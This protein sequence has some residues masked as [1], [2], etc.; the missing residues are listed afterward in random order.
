MAHYP[1][2]ESIHGQ[3][4][5]E[6]FGRYPWSFLLQNDG[7]RAWHTE[8]RYPLKPRVL[9][10]KWQDAATQ[11]GVRFGHKT[12]YAM[13]DIDT[14][15]E[16]LNSAKIADLTA[17]LETMGIVRVVR[18]RS[19]FSGGLHLFLPLPELVNTFN[20]AVAL[21]GTLQA[22]GFTVA[23]GQLEIF[24]NVKAFGKFWK[25]EFTE[26]QG[27]RL[28][29]QPGSGSALL[30]ESFQ[31]VGATLERFWWTWDFAAQA[32]DLDLLLQ[33][34]S[35]GKKNRRRHKRISTP[36]EQ[37]RSDLETQIKDGWTDFGQTNHML[38][39]LGT[40][41]RVFLGL[42]GSEL[43]DFI[44]ERAI[45][46]P[47]FDR[48]C[49][50]QHEIHRKALCWAR[51]LENYYFPA[52]Q[53]GTKGSPYPSE[54]VSTNGNQERSY[55]AQK[56][57]WRAIE[58]I[59]SGIEAIPDTIGGWV[60]R[61]V[62]LAKV[63]SRTLYKHPEW[64]HPRCKKP[65]DTSYLSLLEGENPTSDDQTQQTPQCPLLK[66]FLHLPPGMKSSPTEN[67]H[68]KNLPQGERGGAG[69]EGGLS[70]GFEGV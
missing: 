55:D 63:S 22:A 8:S 62:E 16:Y 35:T 54:G 19:S 39:Q 3:R 37:W 25:G 1:L 26:Y 58:L 31:P 14:G 5:C 68:L 24:P 65:I 18:V 4:L 38:K 51:S 27:H 6:T 42:E 44:V 11:I 48:W 47:G 67:W 59:E 69:G 13:I 61:L 10:A 66:L 53:G 15:S 49:Q 28:P 17:A 7:D 56:R 43:A 32:Q 50:H 2:P 9:W 64:W 52:S 60:D 29:L 70:T 45:A 23:E 34:L 41:G 46:A 40:Y 12:N 21:K 36:L 33:A 57:I 20:L 30:N